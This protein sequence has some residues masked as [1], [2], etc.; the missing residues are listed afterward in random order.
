MNITPRLAAIATAALLVVGIAAGATP[1]SASERMADRLPLHI[2]TCAHMLPA[3]SWLLPGFSSARRYTATSLNPASTALIRNMITSSQH[4]TCSWAVGGH[5]TR[6]LTISEAYLSAAKVTR[7]QNWYASQGIIGQSAGGPTLTYYVPIKAHPTW[8]QLQTLS[9]TGAF[10][11]VTDRYFDIG[12]AFDQDAF[13][14][15]YSHNTWIN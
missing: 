11:S 1:A 3:S 4:R 9:P 5:S 2:P 7:L 13:D 10:I 15:L 12:G 6:S 8:I 14:V